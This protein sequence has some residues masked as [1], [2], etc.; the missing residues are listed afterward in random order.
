MLDAWDVGDP[1]PP[2]PGGTNL[3]G[4]L[5]G[6]VDL[7]LNDSERLGYSIQD[8]PVFSLD[9]L[10]RSATKG[11]G[12]C[13]AA[14][15][16]SD[17]V[18]LGTA[19]GFLLRYDFSSGTAPV[20][21]CEATK[22]P[23]TRIDS[24]FL[25]PTA[26]HALICASHPPPP[27]RRRGLPGF[28]THGSATADSATD[29][30]DA[31]HEVLYLHSS[32]PRPRPLAKLKGLEATAIA[33]AGTARGETRTTTGQI[34]V[35]TAAGEIWLAAIEQADGKERERTAA[36]AYRLP[37][38][39]D[40]LHGLAVLPVGA[41]GRDDA[42]RCLVLAA[43]SSRLYFF[44]GPAALDRLFADLEGDPGFIE[45]PG[46]LPTSALSV[47][48]ASDGAT[49][50][51]AWLTGPGVYVADL[52]H[53]TGPW[54]GGVP[55][56]R[57]SAFI[58]SQGL[59]PYPELTHGAVEEPGV[60][61]PVSLQQTEHHV[62]LL[63]PGRVIA[64]N[65][66]TQQVVQELSLRG[67]MAQSVPIAILRDP[68]AGTVY[69][70]GTDELFEVGVR[71]E[72]RDM[73]RVLTAQGRFAD[74]MRLCR[75]RR[76]RD[77]VLSAQGDD[78][79]KAG[80]FKAA[81]EAFAS[82]ATPEQSFEA[83][84][85]RFVEA[86]AP[87]ALRTYL[88][89]RLRLMPREGGGRAQATMLATW[90]TELLLDWVNRTLLDSGAESQEYDEA[91]RELRLFLEDH[92]DDLD[93]AITT[94][95]LS[96]YTRMDD[97]AHYAILRGNYALVLQH[98]LQK[99]DAERALGV[100]RRP[101]VPVAQHYAA[102][103][104]L[105]QL[106][107]GPT[108]DTWIQ[109]GS[110]LDPT[111]LLPALAPMAEDGAPPEGRKHALRYLDFCAHVLRCQHQSIH[112]LMVALLAIPDEGAADASDAAAAA[113]AADAMGGSDVGAP[114]TAT[115][116]RLLA[117]LLSAKGP[118]AAA[119]YDTQAAL[120]VCHDRGHRRAA[121]QL[122]CD[123]GLY[124]RALTLAL[125]IGGVS[126]A[127]TVAE[128]PEEDEARRRLW[129]PI[130]EH[131]VKQAGGAGGTRQVLELLAESGGA[132]RIEDVLPLFPDF[133][134]IDDFKDAICES[135][136][137]YNRQIDD[138]RRDMDAKAASAHAL[139]DDL[140]RLARR[141]AT[142]DLNSPCAH[143]T[144]A[145]QTPPSLSPLPAL[146][147]PGISPPEAPL[148][149]AVSDVTGP[150][151]RENS[152][153][154]SGPAKYAASA[155]R[156]PSLAPTASAAASSRELDVPEVPSQAQLCAAVPPYY[157]Y[158]C[159][160]CFH[161]TCNLA[162]VAALISEQ[163]GALV[164]DTVQGLVDVG[165]VVGLSEEQ[166]VMMRWM[167]DGPLAADVRGA[168]AGA[169]AAVVGLLGAA[170]GDAGRGDEGGAARAPEPPQSER[171]RELC[172][173]LDSLVGS[174][175]PVCGEIAVRLIDRAFDTSGPEAERWKL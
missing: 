73:W 26:A 28:G 53:L 57:E 47:Q 84:T 61:Q 169:N 88:A 65:R 133:M 171:I 6:D 32:W 173:V 29:G 166:R 80:D 4:S 25:S 152:R 126:L 139:R 34:L 129:V 36:L 16:A 15:A 46:A 70:V 27:P 148:A 13:T 117:F 48:L 66:T 8:L 172:G 74:A 123:L 140:A 71:D 91:C 5:L 39:R 175:C 118:S 137:D 69:L 111:R 79:M 170:E 101:S 131:C 37:D 11:R 42:Q 151:S 85:L 158:P 54:E 144:L 105:M 40:P 109:C 130:A 122:Y 114:A 104:G 167:E 168:Q 77:A 92:C 19:R 174:D 147:W 50:R 63:Y 146:N 31:V 135:L 60:E 99:G 23:G 160:H 108:V 150:A 157:I 83:V 107:P 119:L 33:W 156:A 22:H 154:G 55:P 96:S 1:L 120:K 76:Q 93:E 149:D 59:M 128:I 98:L 102:A 138:L 12:Q 113:V 35:G 86:G 162:A 72:G 132:L 82:M 20:L 110:R 155:A 30:A 44:L 43:T 68:A 10:D 49:A 14:A 94:D 9:A 164:R 41:A 125:E 3:Q 143:C 62:L 56:T 75:T 58:A 145:L 153:H 90:L 24:V 163:Q 159:G 141:T 87:D 7:A 142:L 127:R 2:S 81:A 52:A 112:D 165:R 103:P 64:T 38:D 21:D 67:R 89:T 17:H 124:D 121:L 136:E 115:E 116:A 161:G 106:A 51:C 100:L 18:V 78:A 97:L 134:V 95:L 45:L